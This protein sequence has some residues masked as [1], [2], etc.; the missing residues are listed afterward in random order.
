MTDK[1]VIGEQWSKWDRKDYKY[2]Q[3]SARHMPVGYE[4][5]KGLKCYELVHKILMPINTCPRCDSHNT[6]H[7][8]I[9]N[10]G[11]ITDNVWRSERLIEGKSM[12]YRK[13]D[14]C[15]DCHKEFLIE[16]FCYKRISLL[17]YFMN[18]MRGG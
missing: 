1:N 10:W 18:F 17:K 13:W 15:F 7:I 9:Q 6:Y 16:M 12:R 2:L 5:R 14:Y 3:M 8:H 11:D 4:F